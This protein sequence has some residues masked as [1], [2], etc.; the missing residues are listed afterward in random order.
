MFEWIVN[1]IKL[2][3]ERIY[4]THTFHIFRQGSTET[5]TTQNRVKA[6]T[7][8]ILTSSIMKNLYIIIYLNDIQLYFQL[9]I[10][11]FIAFYKN[12]FLNH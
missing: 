6:A 1:I 4:K 2:K 3:I 12:A 10:I 7:T 8:T 11:K 9:A 5:V